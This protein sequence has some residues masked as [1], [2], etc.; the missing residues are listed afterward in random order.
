[1]G[2]YTG[3][4]IDLVLR[5][6]TPA[7]VLE[8]IRWMLDYEEDE[9]PALAGQDHPFFV[10]RKR[11]S[12]LTGYSSYFEYPEKV[13]SESLILQDDGTYKLSTASSTK[14]RERTLAEFLHW[15]L[16]WT[17]SS[18]EEPKIVGQALYEENYDPYC[19]FVHQN[20]LLWVRY[21]ALPKSEQWPLASGF[22]DCYDARHDFSGTL[23]LDLHRADLNKM[24]AQAE[25]FDV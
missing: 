12:L 18:E 8:I 17:V 20:Q 22:R 16:P 15:L 2:N 9:P 25:E 13:G 10:G 6:E 3:F 4:K 1:M 11:F 24:L 7:N 19:A 21:I 23:E 5:A 14:D